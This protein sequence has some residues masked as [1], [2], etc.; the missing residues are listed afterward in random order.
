LLLLSIIMM[1]LMLVALGIFFYIADNAPENASSIGWLP[2]T[3]LNVYIFFFAIG[4]GP[5]PWLLLSEIYSK[6]YNA[7]ASPITAAI[8]WGLAFVITLT[9]GSISDAI[10]KGETF[11]CFAAFSAIGTIFTFLFVPETKG[12]S[13]ADVQRMLSG[14]KTES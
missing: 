7:V 1:T 6:E 12:K 9:F 11:F 8:N 2:L 14:E 10:G 13:I 3:S 4:Y 5:I